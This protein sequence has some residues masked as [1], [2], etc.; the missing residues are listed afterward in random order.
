M[1]LQSYRILEGTP[2]VDLRTLGKSR[3]GDM[4]VE[5]IDPVEVTPQGGMVQVQYADAIIALACGRPIRPF[6]ES[7]AIAELFLLKNLQ[8]S[9]RIWGAFRSRC[10][11][12]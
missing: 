1:E 11:S 12:M 8:C 6:D 4:E 9:A 3:V 10:V 2:D 7:A 5:V